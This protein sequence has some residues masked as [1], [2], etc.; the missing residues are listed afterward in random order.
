MRAIIKI[1]GITNIELNFPEA[2]NPKDAN[3]NTIM[4]ANEM[5]WRFISSLLRSFSNASTWLDSTLS[6]IH[7]PTFPI[8]YT[9]VNTNTQMTSIKCQ[10]KLNVLNLGAL[11]KLRPRFALRNI[12]VINHIIPKVTCPPWNPTN[13]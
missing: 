7:Y 2:T 11:Y 3:V 5:T 6:V 13:V 10:Y 12:S 8:M 9:T 1:T 4:R